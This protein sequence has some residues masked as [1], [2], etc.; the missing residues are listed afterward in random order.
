MARTGRR[1]GNADTRQQ[2]VDVARA[3]FAEQGYDAVSLRAVARGA[4]VDP[5]LIHH[6][7]DGKSGLFAEVLQLPLDPATVL[8]AVLSGDLDR[9]GERL[10]RFFLELWESPETGPRMRA[11]VRAALSS[12]QASARLGDF[13]VR[14]VLGR[15]ADRLG[16]DRALLRATLTGTQLIGLA[17][18]RYL[19]QAGPLRQASIEQIVAAVAPTLQRYLTGRLPT[20]RADTAEQG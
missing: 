17:V 19:V 5:A 10:L 6:Y 4:G 14:E 7:F 16:S 20:D 15:L 18:V 11:A 3:Q 9:L 12:E 13:V 2:I 1:P 8:P